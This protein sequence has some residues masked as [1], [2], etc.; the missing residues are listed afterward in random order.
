MPRPQVTEENR[1]WWT[2]FAISF[3]LFVINLDNTVVVV[4]LP[5]MS[6]DLNASFTTTEWIVNAY[7]LVFAVLLLFGGRMA[8]LFGRR[9]AL[10]VG[11][12]I[13][14]VASVACALATDGTF[15]LVARAIQGVGAA[16]MLP[17]TLS[18][19]S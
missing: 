3:S 13:F 9:R 16:L 7:A 5:Q 4:A 6:A 10:L 1:K 18:L 2:L 15:I 14:E 11:L 8:D 12:V 17:A 19:V